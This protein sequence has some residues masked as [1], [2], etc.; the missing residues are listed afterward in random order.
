MKCRVVKMRTT[1]IAIPKHELANQVELCG[2]L[3]V[4]DTHETSYN[5]IIKLAQLVHP[6]KGKRIDTLFEVHILWMNEDRFALTGFE[7]VANREG[8]WIDYAQTWLCKLDLPE[9]LLPSDND[10]VRRRRY[11]EYREPSGRLSA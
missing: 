10:R 6:P 7:R 2:D 3:R 1:G 8:K 4:V 5:R 11:D 9:P